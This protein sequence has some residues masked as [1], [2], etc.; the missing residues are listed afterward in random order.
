[1]RGPDAPLMLPCRCRVKAEGGS[2]KCRRDP[3]APF[4]RF[5]YR[6]PY[7]PRPRDV[8]ARVSGPEKIGSRV[9]L[10]L[11]DQG[12][13]VELHR[14]GIWRSEARHGAG[15]LDLGSGGDR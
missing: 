12:G 9:C 3:H 11:A 5:P 10:A 14:R 8:L 15:V 4:S 7:T 1:V 6:P 2:V 13:Q